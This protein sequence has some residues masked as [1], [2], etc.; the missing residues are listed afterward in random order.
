MHMF[1]CVTVSTAHIVVTKQPSHTHTDKE[2][3][4][5]YMV[6]TEMCVLGLRVEARPGEGTKM[7]W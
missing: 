7:E 4:K 5:V 6:L 2:K 1:T 3:H